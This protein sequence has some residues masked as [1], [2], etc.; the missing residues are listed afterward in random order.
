MAL[1]PDTLAL[2]ATTG[3]SAPVLAALGRPQ[4]TTWLRLVSTPRLIRLD[5]SEFVG[6][7]LRQM[8]QGC[9]AALR[10]RRDTLPESTLILIACFL[11]CFL[12]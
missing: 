10:E 8:L 11:S 1:S 7:V 3:F 4:G 6:R 9:G 2:T 5:L 12:A